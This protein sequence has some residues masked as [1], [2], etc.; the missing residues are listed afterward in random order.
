MVYFSYDFKYNIYEKKFFV[1]KIQSME[2]NDISENKVEVS[3]SHLMAKAN[4]VNSYYL[5]LNKGLVYLCGVKRIV[6][7]LSVFLYI[8]VNF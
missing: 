4:R 6:I 1:D 3:A 5:I 7:K 8:E 2:Y